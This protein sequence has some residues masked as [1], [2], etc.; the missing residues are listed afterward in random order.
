MKLR[1]STPLT[2]CLVVL[3]V[4]LA[5]CWTSSSNPE[6]KSSMIW[7]LVGIGDCPGHDDP[8]TT[9]GF[10]PDDSRAKAG[11]TAVCWDNDVYSNELNLGK[12]FCTY[13]NIAYTACKDG[14][15]PGEMYTAV[16][17]K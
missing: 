1:L 15:Y 9:D 14:E 11:Y 2:I 3:A 13:K 8:E 17:R 4:I 5:S 7:E 16:Y 12:A 10:L 6:P